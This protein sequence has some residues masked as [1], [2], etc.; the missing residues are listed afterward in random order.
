MSNVINISNFVVVVKVV[1]VM[2]HIVISHYYH[3]FV[4]L[5][6]LL[7]FVKYHLPTVGFVNDIITIGDI[8][9][10]WEGLLTVYR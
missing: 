10:F 4:F 3:F 2:V 9:D 5:M 7:P 1:V 8:Q 6:G